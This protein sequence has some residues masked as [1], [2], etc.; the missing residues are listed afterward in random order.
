MGGWAKAAEL[1]Q[2]LCFA[3]LQLLKAV[4]FLLLQGFKFNVQDP[5]K[6]L[7]QELKARGLGGVRH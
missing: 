1:G 7:G 2:Q 3:G 6:L 4:K 5:V